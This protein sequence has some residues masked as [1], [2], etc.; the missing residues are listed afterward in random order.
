MPITSD[1]PCETTRLPETA[2]TDAKAP[3]ARGRGAGGAVRALTGTGAPAAAGAPD[4]GSGGVTRL[5]DPTTREIG[6]ETGVLEAVEPEPEHQDR[7]ARDLLGLRRVGARDR[8]ARQR[9]RLGVPLARE[10]AGL[11][12]PA[13]QGRPVVP[14]PVEEADV[15]AI[16]DLGGV[17][18]TLGQVAE[19]QALE[20]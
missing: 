2:T 11:R 4:G 18:E 10:N 14:V 6:R 15:A 5:R 8:D 13:Q 1:S 7:M 17:D 19:E 16:A 9:S 3:W 12:D 20:N